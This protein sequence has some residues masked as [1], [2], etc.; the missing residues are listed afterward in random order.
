M[1]RTS[2]VS[3]A[4]ATVLAAGP[5]SGQTRP[6]VQEQEEMHAAQFFVGKWNCAHTGRDGA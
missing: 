4:I 6:T 2:I 1:N 3:M 5:V